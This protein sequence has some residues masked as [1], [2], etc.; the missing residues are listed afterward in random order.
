MVSVEHEGRR[1]SPPA[2]SLVMVL[3][4][5]AW[6]FC[7]KTSRWQPAAGMRQVLSLVFLRRQKCWVMVVSRMVTATRFPPVQTTAACP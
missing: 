1:V 7:L 2:A 4:F 3:V 5:G 6:G